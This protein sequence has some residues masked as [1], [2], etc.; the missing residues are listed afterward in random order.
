ML[1]RKHRGG[2]LRFFSHEDF[3]FVIVGSIKVAYIPPGEDQ[4]VRS[5]FYPS[6]SGSAFPRCGNQNSHCRTTRQAI[7]T[8]NKDEKNKKSKREQN[9]SYSESA[10]ER[11]NKVRAWATRFVGEIPSSKT[12]RLQDIESQLE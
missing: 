4:A 2:K 6:K 8:R 1:V 7:R 11:Y 10:F 5:S 9:R 3:F 12:L